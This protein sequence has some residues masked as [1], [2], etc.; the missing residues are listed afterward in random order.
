MSETIV[1]GAPPLARPTETTSATLEVRRLVT[2]FRT[3]SGTLRAVNEVSFRL[4]RGR[5]LAV[6]G[7][8]GSGKS[9]MLRSILGI[10]P[11]SAIVTGEVLLGG[12]DLLRLSPKE[13][14]A[15]RGRDVSMVF[16]DPLTA[17]DPVY[18]V[19]QQLVET[20]RTHA[21]VSRSTARRRALELLELVQIPSPAERLSAYPSELSGG[22]R[23]RVVIAMAVA[24]SP[25]VLLA[26]EP[27]TAL[28]VTVQARILRLFRELQ[29]AQDMDMMIVTHDLAVAAD[30]ADDVAV[31]YAG[32]IVEAGPI[33]TVLRAPSHPYTQGLVEA[34]VRPGQRI[35]PRAIPGAPPSLARLPP[36][37]SFAPRCDVATVACWQELPEPV[38]VGPGRWSRCLHSTPSGPVESP[39][40]A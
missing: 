15:T 5:V 21:E 24:G 16:Q 14:A 13:R 23:Q 4:D 30:I 27:T 26:D 7:E 32:R 25:K 10:Q 28:D 19:E 33:G 11:K 35:R 29:Q 3:E 34:N 9:A 38:A 6:I 39:H 31:M 12:R 8:S 40:V 2:D 17:L 1:T 22:M 18:T 36:G 20:V 37:C